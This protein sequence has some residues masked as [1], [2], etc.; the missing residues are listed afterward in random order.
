MTD[1][2]RFYLWLLGTA[3]GFLIVFLVNSATDSRA[4]PRGPMCPPVNC[5]PC[6]TRMSR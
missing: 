6:P 2:R 3:I 1:W 4:R 5:C